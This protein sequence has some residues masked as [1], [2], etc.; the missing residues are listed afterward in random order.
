[1][2][3]HDLVTD[4]SKLATYGKFI[5]PEEAYDRLQQ[6]DTAPYLIRAVASIPYWAY[7]YARDIIK[8]RF[9]EGEKVIASDPHCVDRP[10]YAYLYARDIID[11][12]WPEG[13]KAIASDPEYAYYYARDIIKGRFPEGEKAIASDLYWAYFYQAY[14]YHSTLPTFPD[15]QL[16]V[17]PMIN[18]PSLQYLSHFDVDLIN[19]RFP[20]GEKVTSDEYQDLND[21]EPT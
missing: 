4:P 12:R 10:Y 15:A 18:L 9:P 20:E 5:S 7:R 13:E 8:G 14:F 2:N 1:M 6:G 19:G 11:G 3:L 21:N 16:E 17:D